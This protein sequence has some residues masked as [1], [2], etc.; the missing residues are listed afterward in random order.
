MPA[1]KFICPNGAET[2]IT[3]CLKQC[4]AHHRCLFLPTLRAIAQSVDRKLPKA[5]V[6]ELLCGTREMY[7]R[8]ITDYAVSPTDQVFALHGSAVHALQENLTAGELLSEER[9][10]DTVT[11]G[12]FDLYGKILGNDD[13]VLGDYKVTSSYKLMK[14]LGYYK[15][16]VPTGEFYK[17]GIRKG[18]PKYKKEW[19]TDGVRDVFEWAVQ[20]NAYRMLLEKAG[21]HVHH[22]E[23]QAFCRDYSLQI[24]AQRNIT[25][26]IYLIP[27]HR[28]SN[29]WL[30]LYLKAKAQRLEKAIA[31]RTMPPVCTARENWNGRKCLGYCP[32][33]GHCP[34][35]SMLQAEKNRQIG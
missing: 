1:T 3:T 15:V 31:T 30:E 10:Q 24:A 2:E 9:L 21:F 28:I 4:P 6:T 5:S 33:S 7:L 34:Y 29:H 32:V 16:D 25:K 17:S 20:L 26:P 22:M 13:G 27:I 8:K 18:Q 23:I 12:K 19:R 11:T 35:G 14:A